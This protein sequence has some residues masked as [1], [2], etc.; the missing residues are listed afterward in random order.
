MLNWLRWL[1]ENVSTYGA[2][3]DAVFGLIYYLTVIWF[4]ITF[5]AL[6]WFLVRY[7]RREG[8]RAAYVRGER[9][10]EVAWLLVPVAVVLVLDFWIDFKGAPVWA[11]VKIEQPPA[12]LTVRVTG[13]QFNWEV[14]YPGPDGRFDTADDRT[15]DNEIHVPVGKP[16]RLELRSKDVIH[17]FFLPNLRLKQDVVPGRVID[18]WFEATKTGK[19]ELPCAMLCGFG[20]SGMKGY[21]FVETPEAFA[22]WLAEQWRS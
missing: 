2:D 13:K 10:G 17:S 20:H 19:Y 6:G 12:E 14:V 15:F 7:R 8:R 21:L 11:R 4:F 9:L 3:I 16:V 22:Q 5:G 18:A 1:P